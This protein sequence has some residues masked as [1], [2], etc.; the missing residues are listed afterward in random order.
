MKRL[1]KVKVKVTEAHYM[2]IEAEDYEEAQRSAERCASDQVN[3]RST[4]GDTNVQVVY[5][6]DVKA[7]KKMVVGD[8][9]SYRYLD[10]DDSGYIT[11]KSTGGINETT[12]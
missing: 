7:N 12:R 8:I 6:K 11:F 1:Y 4:L 5:V 9:K 2:M 3:D 10:E